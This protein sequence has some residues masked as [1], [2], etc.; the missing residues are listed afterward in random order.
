VILDL[1]Q[2]ENITVRRVLNTE[3]GLVAKLGVTEFPSCYLYYP[4][5]N[6]T[7]LRVNFEARSFYSYALQRLPG[8][9][10]SGK[11][12]PVV[13]E[14]LKNRTEDPWRPFNSSRV[15]MADLESALHYSLRVELADH[16]VIKGDALIALKNYISVLAKCCVETL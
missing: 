2:F 12:P 4:H 9:M 5:G 15:Y 8:V 6:F 13:M 14:L 7:R 11:S 10:R 1:L 3:K 16:A